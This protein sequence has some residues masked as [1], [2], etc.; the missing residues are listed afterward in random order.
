[1][2]LAFS[3]SPITLVLSSVLLAFYTISSTATSAM[4]LELVSLEQQGKWGG[5]LGLFT[6]LLSVPAPIIG[7][8]IWREIGPLY[9]F[10]IP[11]VVDL[12]LRI[13][14]LATV[15]ETLDTAE[16]PEGHNGQHDRSDS[17]GEGWGH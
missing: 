12:A 5:V 9:V 16:R 14:L 2:L 10:I 7:G 13:P 15:K 17:G 3:P 4:T 11:V 1:L 8:L 6:G